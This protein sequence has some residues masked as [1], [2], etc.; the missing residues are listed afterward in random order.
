MLPASLW[1]SLAENL[2][3]ESTHRSDAA[4]PRLWTLNVLALLIPTRAA[5]I[6]VRPPGP[7]EGTLPFALLP[8]Q[9]TDRTL[10]Q[11]GLSQNGWPDDLW[12][13]LSEKWER[14]PS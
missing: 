6:D 14:M 13:E 1:A 8:S 11:N 2:S 4:D 12:P 9:E 10:S 3:P 5:S 7:P